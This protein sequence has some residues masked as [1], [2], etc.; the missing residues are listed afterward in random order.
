M[1][2]PSSGGRLPDELL[3]EVFKLIT[4]LADT[5]IVYK[6][7]INAQLVCKQWRRVAKMFLY[8]RVEIARLDDAVALESALEASQAD[9]EGVFIDTL[10]VGLS[11]FWGGVIDRAN[12]DRLLAQALGIRKM[13]ILHADY[14]P[15]VPTI[16]PPEHLPL[17]PSLLDVTM[18]SSSVLE[19]TV[20][21]SALI[22]GLPSQIRFL[23]L[24]GN[25][26]VPPEVAFQACLT[27]R[28]YGLT[29]QEYPSS[30]TEWI[31]SSSRSTLQMLTVRTVVNLPRLAANH[32]NLRSL[33]ILSEISASS[34]GDFQSFRWLE[35]LEIRATDARQ[36][37]LKTLPD[38]L[39]YLRFWSTDI[40]VG[41]G[42]MLNT[43]EGRRK[44]QG[45]Q[46]IVWDYWFDK[47]EMGGVTLARLQ[48][49]CSTQGRELRTYERKEG[50]RRASKVSCS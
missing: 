3:V 44:L 36:Q 25:H 5:S 28:L 12:F 4:D 20:S 45:L 8:A 14:D 19:A 29:I 9:G 18:I 15:N 33:R 42:E 2:V 30:M 17:L 31:L 32:P 48:E 35:R 13:V 22:R 7:L 6:D 50:G 10:I 11:G 1:G 41:L 34:P 24:P 43:E 38:T 40:A 21:A 16:E 39:K 46:T 27:F 37:V 23:Q 49:V 26:A 47:D